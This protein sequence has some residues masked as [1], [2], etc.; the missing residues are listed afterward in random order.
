MRWGQAPGVVYSDNPNVTGN[1]E[2]GDYIQV[3]T[4]KPTSEGMIRVK[5][6]PHDG[7]EV[8]KTDGQVWIYWAGLAL[9]RLDLVAFTCED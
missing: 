4:P 9:S 5:V 2:A 3:L 8:G 1:I 6:H 7:R